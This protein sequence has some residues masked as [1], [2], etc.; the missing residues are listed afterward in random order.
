V[1]VFRLA[2]GERAQQPAAPVVEERDG[3]YERPGPNGAKKLARGC[4][5]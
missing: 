2:N 5:P 3:V 1:A 4:W